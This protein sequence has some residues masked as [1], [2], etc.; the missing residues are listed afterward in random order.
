MIES[1]ASRRFRTSTHL[2]SIHVSWQD[3]IVYGCKFYYIHLYT[4][5]CLEIA[6]LSH[7]D[8][9]GTAF[10]LDQVECEHTFFFDTLPAYKN[11]L[12]QSQWF[13]LP[14]F[15][16]WLLRFINSYKFGVLRSLS[17]PRICRPEL[18]GWGNCRRTALKRQPLWVFVSSAP[19]GRHSV[20]G[21]HE[22]FTAMSEDPESCSF[23]WVLLWN[24]IVSLQCLQS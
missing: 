2:G 6:K 16:Q 4:D 14:Y 12:M 17:R 20:S 18:Y 21:V 7:M 11:T 13:C 1:A 5:C 22:P 15:G 10:E 9:P 23:D 8:Y 3:A 24:S 19:I